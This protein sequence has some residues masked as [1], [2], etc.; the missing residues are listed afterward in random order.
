MPKNVRTGGVDKMNETKTQV[1]ALLYLVIPVC[2]LGANI[3]LGLI[4]KYSLE[5]K[6]KINFY[7]PLMQN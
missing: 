1:F 2:F 3:M 7:I 6:R 5:R 4:R